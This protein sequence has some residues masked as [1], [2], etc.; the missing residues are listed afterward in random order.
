MSPASAARQMSIGEC[1]F[2]V[3]AK[4]ITTRPFGDGH[5]RPGYQSTDDGDYFQVTAK[6][7]T[8]LPPL[9]PFSATECLP[10]NLNRGYTLPCTEGEGYFHSMTILLSK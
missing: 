10:E 6:L 1:Y 7:I 9:D 4:L 8:T 3:T 2:Q 5:V